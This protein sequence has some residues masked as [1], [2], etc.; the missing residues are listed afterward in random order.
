[1][2]K[3]LDRGREWLIELL[4]SLKDASS[5]PEGWRPAVFLHLPGLATP[6]ARQHFSRQTLIE[7]LF[8]PESTSLSPIKTLDD[9][10][11]GYSMDLVPIQLAL[12]AIREKN[13]ST[14]SDGRTNDLPTIPSLLETSLSPLPS[15]KPRVITGIESPHQLL[16]LISSIGAD[17]VDSEYLVTKL[18]SWGVGLD[19]EFPVRQKTAGG[20]GKRQIGV[21]LYD[22]EYQM[23]F[24]SIGSSSF[25]GA[26]EE[27]SPGDDRP[28]CTCLACSPLSPPT[29]TVLKHGLEPAISE[30]K[31]DVQE[32]R[33]PPF[34][35]AYI[36]H[37]LHT[38]EMSAHTLLT[39]HNHSVLSSFL[40]GVRDVI[41]QSASEAGQ[42][43]ETL[44][45][46]EVREFEETYD[47]DLAVV[48]G[49]IKRWDE[50]DK[51]RGRGRL[52]REKEKEA[53]LAGGTVTAA[54]TS[55]SEGELDVPLK[56]TP[57]GEI[58]EELKEPDQR[59]KE[60]SEGKGERV[61]GEGAVDL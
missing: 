4:K 30:A 9:G 25:R 20:K 45:Q 13:A 12:D 35:R 1:M 38:H 33:K 23:D 31:E 21:N 43:S 15:T 51:A 41:R 29:S 61:R 34:T 52:K 55:P 39:L 19:M 59:V 53:Q 42:D 48:K 28:I 37:L 16:C 56:A 17:I 10:V 5:T 22:E 11:D 60:G 44:F 32:R 27:S 47:A 26:L 54:S 24:T 8:P 57:S 2:G 40:S 46:K 3:S 18:A 58:V 6:M 36:H 49:A 50:V 7:K 14:A